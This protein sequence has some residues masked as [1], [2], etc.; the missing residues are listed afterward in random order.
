MNSIRRMRAYI[1]NGYGKA[2]DVLTLT[3]VATPTPKDREIQIRIKATSVN[4]GDSRLRRADPFLVRLV[5]GFK[6]PKLPIL[7]IV[8]AGEVTAVGSQAQGFKV[9]DAVFGMTEFNQLGTFAEYVCVADT[10]PLALKPS[11]MTFEAAASLP[12]GGHTALD[13]FR[14]AKIQSGQKVLVYGA[15][16]AVGS[17]A[18]QLAKHY[19]AEVTGVCSTR[20]VDLVRSIGA[21]HVIDY[22][23]VP[24]TQIKERYDIVFDTIGQSSAYELEALLTPTGTLILCSMVGPQMWQGIWLQMTRR[25]RKIIG[26]T[27]NVTAQD[28]DFLRQ[29][30]E[31][32]ELKAVVDTIYP[33]EEMVAAHNHVDTGRKRGNVV[34]SVGG[35]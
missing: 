16:G 11:N 24:L 13:F 26:G 27:V 17:S 21:D 14:K 3:E 35:K 2:E 29:R 19:G 8:L 33:F 18:V 23:Q 31:A 30:A 7:G 20:N 9:G 15:S 1:C 6:K 22:T 12:F 4:S 25:K 34:V 5:F 10:A 28:M 32:N